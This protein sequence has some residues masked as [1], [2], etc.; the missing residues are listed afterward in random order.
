MPT[1][2]ASSTK[3]RVTSLPQRSSFRRGGVGFC[4]CKVEQTASPL[5]HELR[6]LFAAADGQHCFVEALCAT[7]YKEPGAWAEGELSEADREPEK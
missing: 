5:D 3:S 6:M 2:T 1:A 7:L 4:R